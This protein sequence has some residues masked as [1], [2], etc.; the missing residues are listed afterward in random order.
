MVQLFCCTSTC[1]FIIHLG[2]GVLTAPSDGSVTNAKL[3]TAPTLEAKGSGGIHGGVK[4][5]CEA[6][7]HGITL[8]SPQHSAYSGSYELVLPTA[9]GSANTFEK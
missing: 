3:G 8:R 4:Y 5:F 9:Q 2:T 6:G 7:T 1:N